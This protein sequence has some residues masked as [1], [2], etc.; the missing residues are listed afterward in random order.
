MDQPAGVSLLIIM[1][2][3]EELCSSSSSER[4]STGLSLQTQTRVKQ[5]PG[6]YGT[7]KQT[8]KD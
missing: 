8:C 6:A 5:Q 1:L 2:L 3:D 4:C 7:K